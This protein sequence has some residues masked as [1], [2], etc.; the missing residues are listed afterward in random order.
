MADWPRVF[1]VATVTL[2]SLSIVA[3]S[4]ILV[5]EADLDESGESERA[6]GGFAMGIGAAVG[7]FFIFLLWALSVLLWVLTALCLLG[8][9]VARRRAAQPSA[10]P[11]GP[12]RAG[13]AGLL[14][15]LL[16]ALLGLAAAGL[17]GLCFADLWKGSEV[18]LVRWFAV[19]LGLAF[20]T[21]LAG[22]ALL[23]LAGGQPRAGP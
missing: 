13:P 12:T 6:L 19:G 23:P 15:S 3:T 8:F 1:F 22:R 2:G 9:L 7:G 4:W 17:M 10:S 11:P 16:A 21:A 18:R 5:V 14:L 20:G